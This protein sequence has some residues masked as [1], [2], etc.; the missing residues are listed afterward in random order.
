[1]SYRF[2]R[3]L[4][5]FDLP[6]ETPEDRRAYRRFRKN[7]IENGFSML[8][9]SVYSKLLITPSAEATT[10]SAIQ[11]EKPKSGIITS[12]VVTEKQFASMTYLVGEYHNE[13]LD[14]D[15]RLVII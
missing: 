12:L 2:M 14:S 13:V 6:T 5:M 8:Q 3:M 7:L 4:V 10:L 11:K 1:M 15:E 9:E